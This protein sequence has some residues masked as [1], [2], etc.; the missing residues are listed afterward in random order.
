MKE[1]ILITGATGNVGEATIESLID[2]ID[3]DN[4]I[5]AVRDID[6]AKERLDEALHYR[7]LDFE[8]K[9]TFR[10]NLEDIDKI[11]LVRPPAISDVSKYI[12]PFIDEADKVGIDQI[13]FLSLQGVENNPLT[14]HHKIE[15]YIK[16][17]DLPYTFLRPSFFMQNLTTTHLEEI[18]ED[19]E[20]FVPAGKGSINYIDVKDIGEIAALV[21]TENGHTDKAYELTGKK[22]YDFYGIAGILSQHLDRKIEY[23]SPSITKFFIRKMFEGFPISKIIVMIGLYTIARF[24]KADE[25]TDT[26]E[27]LLG[28][29]PTSFEDFVEDNLEKWKRE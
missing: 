12:F 5:P 28:R 18:K 22:A 16:K 7:R 3:L 24:G 20:I 25:K 9:E 10:D 6:R 17:L 4:I 23:K 1:K 29:E 15:K 27:R 26:V 19:Q 21:L 2:I 13:V 11:L 14:P 8:R